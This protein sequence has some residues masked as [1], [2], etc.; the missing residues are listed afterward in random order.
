MASTQTNTAQPA[1]IASL[2]A[3]ATLWRRSASGVRRGADDPERVRRDVRR[4]ALAAVALASVL[5]VLL[6]VRQL[7][8]AL[9]G[10]PI[11][12]YK[13]DIGIG[14]GCL[15]AAAWLVSLTPRARRSAGVALAGV[16]AVIGVAALL[17]YLVSGPGRVG[18]GTALLL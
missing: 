8:S 13:L 10:P 9:R 2:R 6:L 5:S 15:C 3:R 16:A 17:E 12:G 7:D 1:E 4:F 14:F 11:T 18:G